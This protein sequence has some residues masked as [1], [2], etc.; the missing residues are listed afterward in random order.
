MLSSG[1]RAAWASSILRCEN[2]SMESGPRAALVPFLA[3]L[4][5]GFWNISMS[6]NTPALRLRASG[7]Q[8]SALGHVI[9]LCG[10]SLFCQGAW[11]LSWS[12]MFL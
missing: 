12:Q 4:R 1:K 6:S 2:A 5:F 7:T 9:A 8:A 3:C 11:H 10:C